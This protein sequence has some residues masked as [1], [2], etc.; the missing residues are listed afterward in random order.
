MQKLLGLAGGALTT[1]HSQSSAIFPWNIS[2]KT[3][4]VLYFYGLGQNAE[5]KKQHK[6]ALILRC[7]KPSETGDKINRAAHAAVVTD[8]QV[9]VCQD[10][11]G[12]K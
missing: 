3:D 10:D 12:A 8:Q 5:P 6:Q 4:S 11:I 2:D 7:Q 9:K 1:C